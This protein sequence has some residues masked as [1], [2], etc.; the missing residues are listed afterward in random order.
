MF[1]HPP[2]LNVPCT[3]AACACVAACG[4]SWAT[5]KPDTTRTNADSKASGETVLETVR[6]TSE[7][8]LARR[9]VAVDQAR[10]V[11]ERDIAAP[12]VALFLCNLFRCSQSRRG[13]STRIETFSPRDRAVGACISARPVAA[14][15]YCGTLIRETACVGES[16]A[17]LVEMTRFEFACFAG[18]VLGIFPFRKQIPDAAATSGRPMRTLAA[19]PGCHDPQPCGPHRRGAHRPPRATPA[20]G[21]LPA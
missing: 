12:P 15:A 8:N 14:V 19:R 13:L 2:G 3:D 20:R 1:F 18:V 10:V 11:F 16:E 9:N 17:H 4:L 5:P 7:F 6:R 21:R